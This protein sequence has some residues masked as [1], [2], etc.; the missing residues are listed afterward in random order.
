MKIAY[1]YDGV[2]D[3]K[4]LY[5]VGIQAN[6]YF[7][8]SAVFGV[9]LVDMIPI[10]KSCYHLHFSRQLNRG[11]KC[12]FYLS[13][14]LSH[15]SSNMQRTRSPSCSRVSIGHLRKQRDIWS[16]LRPAGQNLYLRF[17]NRNKEQP[18]HPLLQCCFKM[19][20]ATRTPK[21]VSSG[22]LLVSS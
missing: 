4:E 2:T 10:C 15:T 14:S 12:D 3:D 8:Q 7:A 18:A 17:H 9:W 20:R 5:N 11:W 22:R 16:V 21:T 6:H 1:G 13:G 19:Q